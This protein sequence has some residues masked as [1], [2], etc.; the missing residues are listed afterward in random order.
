MKLLRAAATAIALACA[1]PASAQVLDLST[2]KCNEF[3]SAPKDAIAMVV[4]WLDGYYS[5][6]DASAV[7]DFSKV[8]A[9]VTK[10]GEAC[11]KEPGKLLSDVAEDVL[12]K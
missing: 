11:T 8:A 12:G 1:T 5:D 3:L 7:I 9:K 4:M 2:V 6:D 10:M